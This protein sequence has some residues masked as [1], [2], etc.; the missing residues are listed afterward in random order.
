MSNPPKAQPAQTSC[1]QFSNNFTVDNT[2]TI[3][4]I[5]P[6]AANSAVRIRSLFLETVH[7]HRIY[8]CFFY[9][10]VMVG[11]VEASDDALRSV[12]GSTSNSAQS[13]TLLV[14]SKGGSL[15]SSNGHCHA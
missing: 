1:L 12:F 2:K 8:W 11:C 3:N 5:V 15:N 10:R 4:N 9:V 14:R 6:T 7:K 13:A